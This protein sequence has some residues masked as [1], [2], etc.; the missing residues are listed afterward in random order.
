MTAPKSS[1][2]KASVELQP[3]LSVLVATVPERWEKITMLVEELHRQ[4]EATQAAE[5]LIFTNNQWHTVGE[6]RQALVNM[7]RGKYVVFVE[8]TAHVKSDYVDKILGALRLQADSKGPG[9][10]ALLFD[11]ELR[12]YETLGFP[13]CIIARCGQAITPAPAAALVGANIP[14]MLHRSANHWMVYRK[15]VA[16]TQIAPEKAQQ[17]LTQ[18]IRINEALCQVPFHLHE[19]DDRLAAIPVAL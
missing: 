6:Q 13:P 5:L 3:L 15:D 7:A 18:M 2:L 11:V 4:C 19:G 14:A 17:E 9:V 1:T 10:E 16:H 12:G 8:D